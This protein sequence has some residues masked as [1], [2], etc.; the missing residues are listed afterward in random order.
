MLSR[1]NNRC[2]LHLWVKNAVCRALYMGQ[3]ITENS[4]LILT[5]IKY[6]PQTTQIQFETLNDALFP[7]DKMECSSVDLGGGSLNSLISKMSQNIPY[8]SSYCLLV[9]FFC[10]FLGYLLC[11]DFLVPCVIYQQPHKKLKC[12]LSMVLSLIFLSLSSPS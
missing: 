2:P 7:K 1:Q 11:L 9:F 3:T 12:H 5:E 8:L 4:L 10:I 6:F